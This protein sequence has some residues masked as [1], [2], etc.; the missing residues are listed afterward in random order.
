MQIVL[1]VRAATARCSGA[2]QG[3]LQVAELG[4]PGK[5]IRQRDI[6]ELRREVRFV[7]AVRQPWMQS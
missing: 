2:G 6:S 5:R 7:R 4:G 3:I 1:P